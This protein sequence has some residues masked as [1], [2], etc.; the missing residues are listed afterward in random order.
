MVFMTDTH[1]SQLM[2]S[3]ELKRWDALRSCRFQKHVCKEIMNAII[4]A[5]VLN[6]LSQI[7]DHSVTIIVTSPP[8]N[9][10]ID[11]DQHADEAPYADYIK[12]LSS[13][14]KECYRVLRKGGRLI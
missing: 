13:I 10:G 8:Y 7:A 3:V 4:C 14:W 2:K 5:D 1:I 9:I 6:G 11:Y 12:W